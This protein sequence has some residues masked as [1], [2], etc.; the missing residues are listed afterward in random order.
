MATRQAARLKAQ[1]QAALERDEPQT[2]RQQILDEASETVHSGRDVTYGTP[3]DSFRNIA[4]LWSAYWMAKHPGAMNTVTRVFNSHDVAVMMILMKTARLAANPNH[5]DS[6]VDIAG[7]AACLGD[8]QEASSELLGQ[9]RGISSLSQME[10]HG[11]SKE[12][13]AARNETNQ[14]K[15]SL[16]R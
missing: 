12:L 2:A 14:T 8:I 5:H 4:S 6:A 9:G 16:R 15:G 1:V 10:T 7:Y 3:E 13:A 11:L